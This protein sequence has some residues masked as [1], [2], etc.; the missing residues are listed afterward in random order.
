MR[1]T[2]RALT[3][4]FALVAILVLPGAGRGEPL[5]FDLAPG[6]VL[7]SVARYGAFI[8]SL[9]KQAKGTKL[10]PGGTRFAGQTCAGFGDVYQLGAV[11]VFDEAGAVRDL[12]SSRR[13][14]DGAA[15]ESVFHLANVRQ[16]TPPASR[17]ETD[18]E[19]WS[20]VDVSHGVRFEA[21]G[22][23]LDS[24][25]GLIGPSG[26]AGRLR[27]GVDVK[28]AP[29]SAGR[30][31]F[32]IEIRG[33]TSSYDGGLVAWGERRCFT[34]V[35]LEPVDVAVVARLVDA[36]VS[37]STL[38]SRLLSRLAVAESALARGDT[39]AAT[40]G[41]AAFVADVVSMAPDTVSA[42]RARRL[43]SAAFNVRRSLPFLPTTSECGN[44]TRESGE[45][46]DGTDLGGFDCRRL[47]FESGALACRPDCRFDTSGCVGNP[48]C[49]NGI[50]EPGEE[51]DNGPANSDA[52]PDACRTNCRYAFCGDGVIDSF[53][54]CEGRDLDGA[55]CRSEGF[56]RGTLR[57]DDDCSYD[58]DDCIDDYW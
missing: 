6:D 14:R 23:G 58:Y 49:G 26:G 27:F 51:C 19:F 47:G 28:G 31:R 21:D 25:A 55:T 24:D 15:L 13:G 44:G 17:A 54:D 46:C 5:T 40:D 42:T 32:L 18:I 43:V 56:D 53:E 35:D 4:A 52:A 30:Y 1:T 10:V 12:V 3:T 11:T 29:D 22:M 50:V 41:M 2:S 36:F 20:A 16:W 39:A 8:A 38:R 45:A 7:G 57:C 37:V 9:G 33:R 48:V 34:F